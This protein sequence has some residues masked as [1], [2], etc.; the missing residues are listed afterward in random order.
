MLR[1]PGWTNC[2]DSWAMVPSRSPSTWEA[3][4]LALEPA[5]ARLRELGYRFVPPEVLDDERDNPAEPVLIKRLAAALRRLNSWID[6]GNVTRAIRAV[7]QVAAGGLV[8]ANQRVHAALVHNISLDQ[9]LGKG[10]RKSTVRFI[11]F[12]HPDNNELLFTHQY[13]VTGTRQTIVPDLV[14]FVNGLPLVVIECTSPTQDTRLDAAKQQLVHYQD[15]DGTAPE[16]GAPRLF[17]TVQ[18]LIATNGHA[19]SYGTVGM[20]VE[21]WNEWKACHPF[22]LDELTA[23]LGRIPTP[24]DALLHGMLAKRNLLDLVQ[25]F[26]LF[27]V[28]GGGVHKRLAHY[29]QFV[30]VNRAIE[31]I[32]AQRHAARGG[33]ISHVQGSGIM[34]TKVFLANKLRRVMGP[35]LT[36]LVSDSKALDEQDAATFR[37]FGVSGCVQARNANHLRELLGRTNQ[38]I[39]TT[40]QKFHGAVSHD[41]PALNDRE[42]IF[43][44]VEARVEQVLYLDAPLRGR[45]LLQAIA[46]V[47]GVADAKDYGLVVDYWGV[48]AALREAMS[49]LPS[50]MNDA[51]RSKADLASLLRSFHDAVMEFFGP[52]PRDDLEACIRVLEPAD[53]RSA[54]ELAFHRF[55]R[56][57]DMLL[58]DPATQPLIADLLWL[59][60]IRNAARLRFRDD[61]LDLSSCRPKVRALLEASIETH[62]HLP[63]S[64]FSPEL[65]QQL[66]NLESDVARAS[67]LEHAIH[68]EIDQRV[69]A[70]P[71]CYQH[72]AQRL[73]EARTHRDEGRIDADQYLR[74]LRALAQELRCVEDVARSMDL[75]EISLALYELL[76]SEHDARCS[77][78]ASRRREVAISLCKELRELAVVD[79]LQKQDVQR[80]M[81][82]TVKHG[83]RRSGLSS[84][85]VESLTLK[86]MDV[87]RSRLALHRS[88]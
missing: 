23:L 38:T 22:T 71:V 64:V 45:Q 41:E 88:R 70:S 83:L 63:V 80:R 4:Y 43:V 17:H 84:T 37:A 52:H 74:L 85:L 53:T 62:S 13:R 48:A 55:A 56:G 24:Q 79:W 30:A 39:T 5:E 44:L 78:T 26:T 82:Q 46:R 14:V 7:T 51:L 58:P 68:Q 3:R 21:L 11:D 25:N 73:A 49:N 76:G 40:I 35:N 27:D 54:F 32:A 72:I 61:R 66:A 28:V 47:T 9:D 1:L 6:D 20:R 31:R 69:V 2:C 19:A 15:T 34:L 33:I 81:R 29:P 59:G 36:L 10:S 8:E 12:A 18:I 57:L 16:G 86:V 60:A 50:E 87:A 67:E 65:D 42:N 75:D 77:D